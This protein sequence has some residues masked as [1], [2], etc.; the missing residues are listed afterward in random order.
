MIGGLPSLLHLTLLALWRH[1]AFRHLRLAHGFQHLLVGGKVEC[2]SRYSQASLFLRDDGHAGC[3][4]REELLVGVGRFDDDSISH[5]IACGGWFHAN[6][7]HGTFKHIVHVGI[8]GEGHPLPYFHLPDVG[9][10]DV[11]FHLHLGQVVGQGKQGWR[12]ERSSHGLAH[13]NGTIENDAVDGRINLG[14]GQ[15]NPSLVV[16]SLSI[17]LAHLSLRVGILRFLIGSQGGGIRLIELFRAFVCEFR[18]VEL[19]LGRSE[20]R[21]GATQTLV[22]RLLVQFCQ[23]VTFLHHIVEVDVNLLHLT[24][25]LCTHFNGLYWLDGTRCGHSVLNGIFSD[26]MGSDGQ[27]LVG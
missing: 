3:H 4:A 1:L 10:I 23:E 19:A 16:G 20:A 5:H 15:V 8:D 11:G 24:R 6:L 18:V 12:A 9:F 26:H 14:V 25:H 22:E 21:L 13:L 17:S 2:L 7:V 27:F